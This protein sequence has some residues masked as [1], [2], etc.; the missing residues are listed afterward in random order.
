MEEMCE[1][2]DGAQVNKEGVFFIL[3]SEVNGT[4]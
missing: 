1:C 2:V 3:Y 4:D